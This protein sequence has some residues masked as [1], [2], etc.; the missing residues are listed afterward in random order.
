MERNLLTHQRS[1]SPALRTALLVVALVAVGACACKDGSKANGPTGPS[2]GKEDATQGNPADCEKSIDRA[3]ALY[4][5][6]AEA[7]AKPD[8]SEDVKAL[9]AEILEDNVHMV[10][11]DC[12]A[13]PDRFAPCLEKATSVEQMERDCLV[14]LDDEGTVEGK[15]FGGK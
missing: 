4:E 2:T 12:K 13:H 8:D 14:P 6:A 3:R 7:E 11:V 9:R 1:A 15:A 5:K 10:L